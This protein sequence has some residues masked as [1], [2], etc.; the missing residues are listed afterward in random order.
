MPFNKKYQHISKT[1][2]RR[3]RE[4]QVYVTDKEIEVSKE[5]E[6]LMIPYSESYHIMS[7]EAKA[8]APVAR[9]QFLSTIKKYPGVVS[10]V[11]RRP[12]VPLYYSSYQTPE[13]KNELQGQYSQYKKECSVKAPGKD[14]MESV[15]EEQRSKVFRASNAEIAFHEFKHAEQHAQGKYDLIPDFQV[16]LDMSEEER[17]KIPDFEKEAMEYGFRKI[18]EYPY[19]KKPKQ[20]TGKEISKTLELD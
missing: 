15:P 16:Y 17:K 5:K 6:E 14:F 13:Q 4:S 10:E 2:K 7:K 11:E 12:T 20:A 19:L 3:L 1:M 9:Q 8:K 18:K